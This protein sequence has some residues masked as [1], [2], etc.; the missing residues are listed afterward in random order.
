LTSVESANRCTAFERSS[1]LWIDVRCPNSFRGGIIAGCCINYV[2]KVVFFTVNGLRHGAEI[3]EKEANFIGMDLY[4]AI[5]FADPPPKTP[6]DDIEVTLNFGKSP[7]MANFKAYLRVLLP[8][9]NFKMALLMGQQE[10]NY[11]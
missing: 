2:K 3:T 8:S 6:S 10:L 7:F 9:P 4:P 1:R 11:N 5:Q